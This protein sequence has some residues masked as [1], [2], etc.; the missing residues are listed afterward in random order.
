[1]VAKGCGIPKLVPNRTRSWA[2]LVLG[3]VLVLAVPASATGAAG[4]L[5]ATFSLDGKAKTN[6]TTGYDYAIGL[7]VQADGKLVAAGVASRRGGRFALVRYSTN[8]TLDPFFGANGRVLTNFTAGYDVANDLVLQSGGKLVAVGRAG[9]RGGRFALARYMPDGTLDPTFGGD[10]RVTTNFTA[11][12]DFAFGAALDANGNIVAV[13]RAA[14]GGGRIA[15]ARYK[16]ND[17]RL[18]TTFN[19][20]GRVI[21]NLTA[22]DDRADHVAIQADGMIVAAGTAGYLSANARFALVRYQAGGTPDPG[23]SGDGKLTTNCTTGFD[24]AFSVAIQADQRI[25]A[26]GEA[27]Q[28]MGIARYLPNGALDTNFGVGGKATVDFT[29]GLDYADDVALSSSNQIIVAGSANY[30]GRDTKFALARLNAD[31]TPDLG[32]SGDGKRETNLTS[33]W[34]GSFDVEIQPTDGKIV[35]AGGAGNYGARFAIARYLAG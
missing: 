24:G 21:T 9:G 26:A 4:D 11:G 14:G 31:G 28:S 15:V 10:G 19:G 3:V 20:T 27:G 6:V 25:V 5:D 34:D 18:D 12:D 1:V 17:G 2:A 33:G 8:G 23:F 29:A 35:A 13:G 16:A 32:F 22:G 30:F 7:V